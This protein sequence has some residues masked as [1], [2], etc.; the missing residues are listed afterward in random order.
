MRQCITIAAALL[1]AGLACS[2]D[3]GGSGPATPTSTTA[4]E[5]QI[6]DLPTGELVLF[7]GYIVAISSA[8]DRVWVSDAPAAAAW[9]GVEL[10]RGASP[11]ALGAVIGDRVTVEG[12]IQEFGQGGGLTM[13]QIAD[14]EITILTPAAGTPAPVTGLDLATITQDPIAGISANGEPYEGVLVQLSNIKVAATAPY[15]YT[16]GTTTFGAGQQIVTL[17]DAIGTCYAT[18]TGIWN[19]D[20]VADEWIIVPVVGGRVAGSSCP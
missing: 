4:F 10:Y 1:V 5:I 6:H 16:D 13:T 20:A 7:P 3:D 14:P 12:T 15:A 11:G 2:S 17:G 9:S 18:V 8:G 19:Y